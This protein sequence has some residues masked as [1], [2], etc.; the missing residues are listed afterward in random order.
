MRWPGSGWVQLPHFGD[1]D[2][3]DISDG[4]GLLPSG[5]VYFSQLFSFLG[6][7]LDENEIFHYKVCFR[8]YFSYTDR[9]GKAII[10]FG[11][12]DL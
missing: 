12:S 6:G 1:D 10:K 4:V 7:F 3:D 8:N 11:E 9:L 2:Y 5:G